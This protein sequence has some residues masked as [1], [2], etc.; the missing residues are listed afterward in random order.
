MHSLHR[1]FPPVPGLSYRSW[2]TLSIFAVAVVVK[3]DF[4]MVLNYFAMQVSFSRETRGTV[5]D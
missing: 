5:P 2:I 4:V 3:V 1:G